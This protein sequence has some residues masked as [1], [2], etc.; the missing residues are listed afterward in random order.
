MLI[1][2]LPL[3]TR[4]TLYC[5]G[6]S[7]PSIS[8]H[9]CDRPYTIA[10]GATRLTYHNLN[11]N[12]PRVAPRVPLRVSSRVYPPVSHD[13]GGVRRTAFGV[14]RHPRTGAD[15]SAHS[16]PPFW[17]ALNSSEPLSLFRR[18]SLSVLRANAAA[19]AAAAAAI[20]A[21]TFSRLTC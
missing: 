8:S 11:Q 4:H 7:R 1:L 13:A 2:I 20:A 16:R 3:Y 6:G 12:H 21:C 5:V 19:A 10:V 14:F 18:L 15:S 17:H 9:S